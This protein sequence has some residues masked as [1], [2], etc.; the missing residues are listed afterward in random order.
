MLE[1]IGDR[2]TAAYYPAEKLSD[3]VSLCCDLSGQ[4]DTEPLL[5]MT[6]VLDELHYKAERPRPQNLRSGGL[7]LSHRLPD[8]ER[9]DIGAAGPTIIECFAK[10]CKNTSITFRSIHTVLHTR[11]RHMNYTKE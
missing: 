5:T 9:T 11:Q 4:I 3:T 8:E 1:F 7:V 10:R 2:H 6:V